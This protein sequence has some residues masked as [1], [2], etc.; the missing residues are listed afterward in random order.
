VREVQQL[1]TSV[2]SRV[3]RIVAA[4]NKIEISIQNITFKSIGSDSFCFHEVGWVNKYLPP[5]QTATSFA[6]QVNVFKNIRTF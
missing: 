3:P 5:K 4:I 2:C 1:F 6:L